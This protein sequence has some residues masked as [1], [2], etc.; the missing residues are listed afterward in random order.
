[1]ALAKV[2]R[3]D[4]S[5]AELAVWKLQKERIVAEEERRALL[6]K[7]TDLD[8]AP[9]N[10]IPRF[11]IVPAALESSADQLTAQIMAN[12]ASSVTPAVIRSLEVIVEPRLDASS[13]KFWYLAADPMVMPAFAYGYLSGQE[14]PSISTRESWEIRG[15]E[16]KIEMDFGAW[17]T[18]YQPVYRNKGEA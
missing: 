6:R 16:M 2:K 11:L 14:T 10:L 17:K 1:M 9:L 15:L 12:Q 13:E 7:Q 8:S 18:A 5:P 4:P 3:W